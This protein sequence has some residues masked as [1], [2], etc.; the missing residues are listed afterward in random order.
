MNVWWAYLFFIPVH[1]DLGKLSRVAEWRKVKE[2]CLMSCCLG[3]T[4]VLTKEDA[5]LCLFYSWIQAKLGKVQWQGKGFS[6]RRKHG[7]SEL[8][9]HDCFW[10][11][12]GKAPG[13]LFFCAAASEGKTACQQVFRTGAKSLEFRLEVLCFPVSTLPWH[14]ALEVAGTEAKEGDRV[15]G[16]SQLWSSVT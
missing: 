5:A 14:L 11:S 12:S 2:R 4:V 15:W 3:L 7:G 6:D 16:V 10:G 8:M 1:L 9:I 13:F